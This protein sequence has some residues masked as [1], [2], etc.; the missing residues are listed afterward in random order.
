MIE[1]NILGYTG[2]HSPYLQCL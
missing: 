1:F 2:A